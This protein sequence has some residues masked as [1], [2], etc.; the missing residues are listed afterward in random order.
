MRASWYWLVAETTLSDQSPVA[1]WA[2]N[3]LLQRPTHQSVYARQGWD[4]EVLQE[5]GPWRFAPKPDPLAGQTENLPSLPPDAPSEPPLSVD[6]P[7]GTT[8]TD[9]VT[10]LPIGFMQSDVNQLIDQARQAAWQEGHAAA[11]AELLGALTA[12]QQSL[13][14]CALALHELQSDR[15]QMLEPLKRLSIHVAQELVR[16]ELRLDTQVIERLIAACVDA[17]DHPAETVLIQI[18]PADMERLQ[19]LTLPGVNL[20]V[21]DTL[22]EGSVRAKVNDTQ[23]EDLIEHRLAAISRQIMGEAP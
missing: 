7:E 20:E 13:H 8:S 23:V 6:A 14:A 10:D 9:V 19:G 4:Q 12:Q 18:S 11:V 17:L 21:D 5:F 1:A 15:H 22:Q 2:P 3:A 16:G